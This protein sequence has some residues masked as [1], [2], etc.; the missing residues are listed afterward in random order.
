MNK[1]LLKTLVEQ[2]LVHTR[3]RVRRW[4]KAQSWTDQSFDI[5]KIANWHPKIGADA[6][7]EIDGMT[8][9]R[10]AKVYNI[11]P[12][13][14]VKIVKKRGRKPKHEQKITV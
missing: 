6:I 12:D 7:L 4:T 11:K 3:T 2:G 10:F 1:K 5:I 13:G 8:P 9:E 14:T